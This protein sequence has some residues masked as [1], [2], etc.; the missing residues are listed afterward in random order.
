MY[1]IMISDETEWQELHF[2]LLLFS[3]NSANDN[4]KVKNLLNELEK[5]IK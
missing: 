4:V 5:I 3:T 1:Y 2:K